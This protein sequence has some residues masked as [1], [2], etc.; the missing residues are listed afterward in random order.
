MEGVDNENPLNSKLF[1][2]TNK[3]NTNDVALLA[4]QRLNQAGEVATPN[5]TVNIPGLGDLFQQQLP[6]VVGPLAAQN[7]NLPTSAVYRCS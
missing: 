1:N 3:Q 2:P 6:P 5:I 4:R 7:V